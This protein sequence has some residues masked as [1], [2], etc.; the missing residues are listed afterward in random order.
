[1]IGGTDL[2]ILTTLAPSLAR[3]AALGYLKNLWPAGKFE[4]DDATDFF[5]YKDQAS[6]EAWNGTSADPSKHPMVYVL[7]RNGHITFVHT[8]LDEADVRRVFEAAEQP[9]GTQ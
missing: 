5:Y 7:P 3:T 8:G 2:V 4:A 6:H 9:T 1:M